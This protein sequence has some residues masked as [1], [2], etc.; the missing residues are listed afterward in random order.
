MTGDGGAAARSRQPRRCRCGVRGRGEGGEER[1]RGRGAALARRRRRGAIPATRASG[2][3]SASPTAGSR[4]WRRRWRRSRR[5][6]RWRRTTPL[7]AHSLARCTMEAGLPSVDLF[8]RA[9]ALAPNDGAVLLGRAAAQLADGRIED[10]IA[11]LAGAARAT[12]G[13]AA[14]PCHALPAALAGAASARASPRASRPRSRRRRA[15][16][17]SGANGPTR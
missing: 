2:R 11:G 1:A 3:C 6:P 9:L 14:R 8:E 5:R 12:S 17:R 16:S 15:R 10:A 13:L 4:I 7:I